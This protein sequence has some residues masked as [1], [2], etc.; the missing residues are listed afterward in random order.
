[1]RDLRSDYASWEEAHRQRE[2]EAEITAREA[3]LAKQRG[4]YVDRDNDGAV[5]SPPAIPAGTTADDLRTAAQVIEMLL[6]SD[7]SR[8]KS[9]T[10][11]PY[12]STHQQQ[13]RLLPV[14][15][16]EGWGGTDPEAEEDDLLPGGQ[17]GD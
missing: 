6:I 15:H 9:N 11:V 3:N 1:M 10:D 8:M 14:S 7:H 13:F 17:D 2:K 12:D 5:H 4:F 16:P